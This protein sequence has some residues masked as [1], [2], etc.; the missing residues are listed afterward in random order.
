MKEKL[1]RARS[2]E[3]P[4]KDLETGIQNSENGKKYMQISDKYMIIYV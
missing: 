1:K 4:L 2:E 3:I